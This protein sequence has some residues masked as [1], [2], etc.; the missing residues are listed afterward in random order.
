M[1]RM[2]LQGRFLWLIQDV[3]KVGAIAFTLLL[4]SAV[5][6]S[7]N[8]NTKERVSSL[9]QLTED[10]PATTVKEWLAQ[11]EASV[12]QITNV[13]VEATEEGLQVVL[14]TANGDF[15]VPETR[16]VGNDLIVDIAGAA[17]AQTFSQAN[18]TEGIALVSVTSLPNNQVQVT[19]TG[20]DAPPA[21]E[22]TS[23]AQGLV[24]AVTLEDADTVADEDAIEIVVTGE[25]D[26]GYNPS[27]ASTATRTD[28]PL[29]DIPFSIQVV[30]REVLEDRKVRNL[31]EAVETV[32][33]VA[34][35][36]GLYG[37]GSITYNRIIRGFDQGFSGVTS[38]RNG[39]PDTDFFSLL[40][41]G[42]VEQIEVLRGPASVL[43]GAGEPGGIINFITRQPLD[44]P[45]YNAT[46]AAG[47]YGLYQP[48]I[49]LSEPLTDNNSVLYRFIA[50]YQGSSDFQGFADSRLTTI[51]PSLTFNLGE[52]TELDLY[53]EYTHLYANPSAAGTN[54][55]ILSDGS[56]P[57]RNFAPYYPGLSL[58]NVRV[59][60]FGY[61]LEHELN[62]DWRIR[63]NVALNLTHFRN[64]VAGFPSTVEDDRFVG[65]FDA[66]KDNYQRNNF[67]GQI[68]LVGEFGTGSISHQ[69]LAG[70]DFNRFSNEGNNVDTDTPLP[71]LDI[72]N[73]NYD[74]PTPSYSTIPTF[75]DFNLVR[76]SYG[77]YL[78]DQIA[79]LDNL[80]LLI[81][82]RY[83]W[84]STDLAV[85]LTTPGDVIDRPTRN[86]GAFSPRAGLVYQPSENVA[87][88]ASY[89]RSFAPLSGFDN[90]STDADVIYEPSRGTQYEVGVKADFLD[91]RLSATI[92]AYHL[93]RT[94]VLTPDPDDPTRSIQ[95]GEQR[96]Q[97]IEFDVTGEILPGWNVI[98]SYA[99]TNAEVTKDNTFPEGN[100]LANVP[101]NQA[102]LWTTYTIQEGALEGLGFG[103]GLFYIGERQG[104]LDNS[105]QLGDYLRTDAALYYRRGRFRGAIN[106]RNLFDV[107][108][109]AF[110][111]SRTLVQR[112]EPFT[113]VGSVSWE[114]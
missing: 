23:E 60:R 76:R 63:N 81:G 104:D 59:D 93:T 71:P 102:S 18:P 83:D 106:I 52:R 14:E 105:F 7:E 69:V 108:E 53:Y 10:Q 35:G 40:P 38:F 33:G 99:L 54:T 92:A 8:I 94:N 20:T 25:Q 2:G 113:I 30:P 44:E 84:V 27:S 47:S 112:T 11:I 73:P 26:E 32:S 42:T 1:V 67:F 4:T 82:G 43:F 74:I 5:Y 66:S 111:F 75:S 95:T 55:V 98:L 31:N 58:L 110:A 100:R 87:L 21:A 15:E 50:S 80:K 109:A 3:V 62:N 36:G 22:V 85:D 97:G 51:A 13:R 72:R 89:T 45:Y 65:G 57:P 37:N 56:L 48:S 68:D 96:S 77:V 39:F 91:S 86:D 17:I 107:D 34:R 88:Y 9:P 24:L 90:T 12:V 103:L 101:E 16:I 29:R 19:I 78:Q 79:L 64:D 49:D 61:R 41:I 46:F 28:T 114:F 70:F 6:A